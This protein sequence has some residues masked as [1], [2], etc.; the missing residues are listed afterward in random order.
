VITPSG[1]ATWSIPAIR[2]ADAAVDEII[3]RAA[4]SAGDIFLL[5]MRKNQ[6]DF[7]DARSEQR[8]RIAAFLE[9]RE[10]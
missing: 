5:S 8:A 7:D 6:L 9:R 4:P 1:A 2:A 3:N 10:G